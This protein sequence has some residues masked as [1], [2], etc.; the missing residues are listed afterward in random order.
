M[1]TNTHPII[2]IFLDILVAKGDDDANVLQPKIWF[3]DTL[4]VRAAKPTFP[5]EL[6]RDDSQTDR[7][8]R[9]G[10]TSRSLGGATQRDFERL[11]IMEMTLKAEEFRALLMS[12]RLIFKNRCNLSAAPHG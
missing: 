11:D 12:R 8:F 4:P 7:T 1:K 2:P 10:D 5:S 9:P 6:N 3:S